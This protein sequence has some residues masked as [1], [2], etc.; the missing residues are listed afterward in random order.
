M[1]LRFS[2][3][4]LSTKLKLENLNMLCGDE[5]RAWKVPDMHVPIGCLFLGVA[6]CG[7]QVMV[8]QVVRCCAGRIQITLTREVCQP[9]ESCLLAK[10]AP[11]TPLTFSAPPSRPTL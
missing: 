2:I 5:M 7:Y 10:H 8:Q 9:P 3:C 11:P 6:V 4:D 1:G